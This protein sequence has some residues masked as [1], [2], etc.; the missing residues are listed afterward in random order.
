MFE[1]AVIWAYAAGLFQAI[2]LA[3]SLV[4]LKIRNRIAV[5]A[6]SALMLL[7]AIALIEQIADSSGASHELALS[8]ALEF[9]M[10]PL[11]FLFIRAV[12]LP[13]CRPDRRTSLHFIPLALALC[14]LALMHA[15]NESGNLGIAHPQFGGFIVA[16][17]F[18]K[19]VYFVIYAIFTERMLRHA[20]TDSKGARASSLRW[21]YRWLLLVFVAF[22]F[23][24]A[25]FVLFILGVPIWRDSDVYAGLANFAVIFSIAYFVLANRKILEQAPPKAPTQTPESARNADLIT[26]YFEAER[27]H[28]DPDFSIQKLASETG[29]SAS[30]IQAGLAHLSGSGF[31]EYLNAKRLEEFDALA[32]D[33]KN[34]SKTTLELAFTAGFNSKATF[35]R[36]FN[37]AKG[38]TPRTYRENLQKA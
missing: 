26:Q 3:I 23:S 15:T 31:Q 33:E 22:A 19:L 28:L 6:L 4:T 14:L 7:M 11:L 20:M 2:F 36:V 5:Y 21:I 37:A 18:V 30:M 1:N 17:V 24:Y 29:L 38:I 35:Y 16:W 10:A 8:L 13:D 34:R 12:V 32:L 25:V 9:G 27:P